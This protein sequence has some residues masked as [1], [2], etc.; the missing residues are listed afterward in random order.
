MWE[1]LLGLKPNH[2]CQTKK[3]TSRQG[4][5]KEG[6]VAKMAQQ[7]SNYSKLTEEE[8]CQLEALEGQMVE[9]FGRIDQQARRDEQSERQSATRIRPTTTVQLRKDDEL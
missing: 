1:T 6:L 4:T 5:D 2:C 8:K 9:L 7:L 3:P